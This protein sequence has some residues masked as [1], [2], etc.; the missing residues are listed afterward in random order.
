MRVLPEARLD[1]RKHPQLV[2]KLET[3]GQSPLQWE[4]AVG[5]QRPELSDLPE[6]GYFQTVAL[7]CEN[8]VSLPVPFD[9]HEVGTVGLQRANS[10]CS[11]YDQ[12]GAISILF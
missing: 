11:K 4:E 12:L 7:Q 3:S 5:M 9:L 10:P 1:C 6:M 2:L 8:R